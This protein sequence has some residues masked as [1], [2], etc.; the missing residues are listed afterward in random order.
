[1][2]SGKR[3]LWMQTQTAKIQLCG[4]SNQNFWNKFSVLKPTNYK[5][6]GYWEPINLNGKNDVSVVHPE[7]PTNFSKYQ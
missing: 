3:P 4:S 7:V 1:M 5:K 2:R 6:F